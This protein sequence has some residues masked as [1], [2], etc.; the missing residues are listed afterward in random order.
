MWKI[1]KIS[2]LNI[3]FV[4]DSGIEYRIFSHCFISPHEAERQS[5]ISACERDHR[6]G[7]DISIDLPERSIIDDIRIKGRRDTR[8]SLHFIDRAIHGS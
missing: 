8:P 4:R 6:A 7:K 2:F 1:L 5:M 3:L